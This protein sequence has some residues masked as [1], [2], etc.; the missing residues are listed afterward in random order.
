MG[1]RMEKDP[2]EDKAKAME[3]KLFAVRARFNL[4][5]RILF[6]APTSS[7]RVCQIGMPMIMPGIE[8]KS[9]EDSFCCENGNAARSSPARVLDVS[10]GLLILAWV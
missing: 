5:G 6:T 8:S 2:I 3:E 4:S 9:V 10:Q 7:Q 1:Q